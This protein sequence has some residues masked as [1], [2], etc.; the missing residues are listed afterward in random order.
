MLLICNIRLAL[1]R[2]P[3]D[4]GRRN[5]ALVPKLGGVLSLMSFPTTQ[6]LAASRIFPWV[7]RILSRNRPLCASVTL[8]TT[9]RP[10]NRNRQRVARRN[11]PLCMRDVAV[12]VT[13]DCGSDIWNGIILYYKCAQKEKLGSVNWALIIFP[14]LKVSLIVP[15]QRLLQ[16]ANTQRPVLSSV[17]ISANYCSGG[18]S[19]RKRK[20][21]TSSIERKSAIVVLLEE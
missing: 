19:N 4:G 14:M 11:F 9:F 13:L 15:C 5:V 7:S 6:S 3:K 21:V 2:Q 17:M 18:Q 8:R 10:P 16:N 1:L 20:S 12:D